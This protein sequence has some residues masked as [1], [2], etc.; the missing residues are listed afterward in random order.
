[1]TNLDLGPVVTRAIRVQ[2][3]T[4]RSRAMF[5]DM[6]RAIEFHRLTPA[7]EVASRRF[8]GAAE[9]IGPV[10]EGGHFGK[11]C[12]RAWERHRDLMPTGPC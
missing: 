5:E 8:D 2:A 10:V 1:L 6:A 4:I 9:V 11:L 12:M 7:L 3:V